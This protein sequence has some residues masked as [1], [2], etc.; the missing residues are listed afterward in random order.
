MPREQPGL[1]HFPMKSV[2]IRNSLILVSMI[3]WP[4]Y[5]LAQDPTPDPRFGLVQ[6]RI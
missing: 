5:A 1:A 6:Q 4:A 2:L 3:F